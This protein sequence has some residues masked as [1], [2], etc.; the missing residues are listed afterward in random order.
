M[1]EPDTE[2]KDLR[3]QNPGQGRRRR[4]TRHRRPS[5]D[6]PRG[7]SNP[8]ESLL[9]ELQPRLVEL[10]SQHMNDNPDLAARLLTKYLG[11]KMPEKEKKTLDEIIW[12]E[13]EA[14][15]QLRRRYADDLL[16]K[17]IRKDRTDTDIAREVLELASE[18]AE[19]M[20]GSRWPAV[21]ESAITSGE[22]RKTVEAVVNAR[23]AEPSGPA[24]PSPAQQLAP[25]PDVSHPGIIRKRRRRLRDQKTLELIRSNP[26]PASWLDQK[27]PETG[28]EQATSNNPLPHDRE[29]GTGV[30]SQQPGQKIEREDEPGPR[31]V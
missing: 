5:S 31:L 22:L 30:S 14:N 26:P 27:S 19:R 2:G 20:V 29:S 8:S 7:Q 15:P 3:H 23:A 10:M 21:V 25:T 4:R 12:E 28:P 13:I 17:T 16:E 24:S 1:P 18:I 11:I 9:W 6:Q